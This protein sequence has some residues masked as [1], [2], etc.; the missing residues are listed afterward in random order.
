MDL[1]VCRLSASADYGVILDFKALEVSL[2][3][4]LGALLLYLRLR[5]RRR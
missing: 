3:L 5:K 4:F 2:I 1:H